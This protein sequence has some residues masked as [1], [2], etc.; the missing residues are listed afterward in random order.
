MHARSLVHITDSLFLRVEPHLHPVP[1]PAWAPSH[2]VPTS[3]HIGQRAWLEMDSCSR[4]ASEALSVSVLSRFCL[5]CPARQVCSGTDEDPDDKN[6]PFRQRPFCKYKGHTADLL[7][8]CWSKV[9][10]VG[11]SRQL[12][13]Q[14]FLGC[15]PCTVLCSMPFVAECK[16]SEVCLSL[17]AACL[18][19]R[20]PPTA[21]LSIPGIIHAAFL[22]C[23]ITSC[24]RL[25]WTRR[26]GSGTSPGESAS[27]VSST[28][29]SSR[30]LPST[31]G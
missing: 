13:S 20:P 12:C 26:S 7:D 16:R 31:R 6:T 10:L 25:P 29:T 23:R 4:P 19:G 9:S 18:C 8:L 27:A 1:P 2:A 21:L 24:S 17:G 22:P 15:F 14:Q 3:V 28:L 5:L 30:R 11:G